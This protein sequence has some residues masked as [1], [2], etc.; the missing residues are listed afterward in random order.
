MW[1]CVSLTPFYPI[2]FM[3]WFCLFHLR[4]MFLWWA[5]GTGKDCT[6]FFIG[7]GLCTVTIKSLNLILIH[8]L[9][10]SEEAQALQIQESIVCWYQHP[11]RRLRNGTAH[12]QTLFLILTVESSANVFIDAVCCYVTIR[13]AQIQIPESVVGTDTGG[14][15]VYL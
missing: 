10:S 5:N 6:F 1:L 7:V 15:V 13:D 9:G 11:G 3:R 2:L 12:M 8:S 14:G 4:W